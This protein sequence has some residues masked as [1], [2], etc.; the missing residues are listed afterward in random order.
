MP[1]SPVPTLVSWILLTRGDRPD[2]LAAAIDS[3]RR[4][5]GATDIEVIV[6]ANG[7]EAPVHVDADVTL[8]ETGENLGVP[9]GRNVGADAAGGDLL[10]FLDDDARIVADDLGDRMVAAFAG[11]PT[12]AA[13]S[14]RIVDPEQGRTARR[15]VPRIGGD[16]LESGPVT[17]FL[18]GASAL[19][20][21]AFRDAGGLPE[22]F[23]YALEE[24]D[25]AWRLLD[26]GWGI[27]YDAE[28]TVAH[29][30]TVI[31]RHDFAER[32]TAR[33]RVLLARRRLPW[34]LVPVYILVW[35]VVTV[36]RS[37]RIGTWLHGTRQGLAA[38][39]ERAPMR[40]R[41]VWRMARLGRPPII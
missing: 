14:F 22:S 11:D 23:F 20:T 35:G 15:H 25:L 21:S 36:G 32:L 8:I 30:W 2:D 9:G 37:R 5:A 7:A 29:P 17:Y 3:I 13:L 6:V 27:R 39:V 31:Q 12:L 26:R 33:N 24:S 28:L 18:G 16:P 10:A 38:P 1:T 41:T 19:R 34:P 4:S 40:W